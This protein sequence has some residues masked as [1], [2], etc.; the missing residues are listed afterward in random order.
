MLSS[1]GSFTAPD[2]LRAAKHVFRCV[3]GLEVT[4]HVCFRLIKDDTY[5][6]L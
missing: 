6:I 5:S 2:F 3:G 1:Q 4:L